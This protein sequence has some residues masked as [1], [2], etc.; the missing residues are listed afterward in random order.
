[1][2]FWLN[3][4]QFF[5]GREPVLS[6]NGSN[7]TWGGYSGADEQ[8]QLSHMTKS[9][10]FPKIFESAKEL[11]PSAKR[12]MSFGCS[13]GEEAMTLAELFPDSE[14]VGVDIDNHSV[15][16]AR[17]NNKF[18]DRVYFQTDPGATGK[19]DLV[20]CLM[21]LFSLEKPVPVEKWQTAIRLI[22]KHVNLGGVVMLYTS[23]YDFKSVEVSGNYEPIRE[24][25][26]THERNNK[27]YFCGYYRKVR[28]ND[29]VEPKVVS[30][31]A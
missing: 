30:E 20:T 21:V 3:V 4:K 9:N 17:R 11:Q 14:I 24:W 28:I 15:T 29:Y 8:L 1:M 7:D 23:D 16:T 2:R 26:R 10:R 13:T 12:I 18:R 27:K 19:Y 22:D 31:A 6:H 5:T 25:V